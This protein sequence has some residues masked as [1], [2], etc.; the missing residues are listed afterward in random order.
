MEAP[1]RY[2]YYYPEGSGFYVVSYLGQGKNATAF[3]VQSHADGKYY[4]RRT[5]SRYG[6]HPRQSLMDDINALPKTYLATTASP[7]KVRVSSIVPESKIACSYWEYKNGGDYKDLL[8]HY[9]EAGES[10]PG[11]FLWSLLSH[12]LQATTALQTSL[13]THEDI[14]GGNVFLNWPTHYSQVP[15]FFL[16]DFADAGVYP[17]DLKETFHLVEYSQL[18]AKDTELI[19]DLMIESLTR[20]NVKDPGDRKDLYATILDITDAYKTL[21]SDA[22][23][24]LFNRT[25]LEIQNSVKQHIDRCRANMAA[26]N[27][28]QDTASSF[29]SYNPSPSILTYLTLDAL[30]ENAYCPPGPWRIAEIDNEARTTHLLEDLKCT[31]YFYVSKNDG[32]GVDVLEIREDS[33]LWFPDR[34]D[35]GHGQ[36]SHR[37]H[38]WHYKI[39]DTEEEMTSGQVRSKHESGVGD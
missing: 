6:P 30:K 21:R 19:C 23:L 3:L 26:D 16:G 29:A 14:C 33:G 18:V 9:A 13:I 10:M 20:V 2:A 31:E 8:A 27:N 34:Y 24:P 28:T 11:V 1:K 37:P 7:S 25:M 36:E 35:S 17:E 4:V 32:D 39:H 12:L 15:Q 5:T 38:V 22:G